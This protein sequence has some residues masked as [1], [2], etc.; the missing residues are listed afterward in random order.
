MSE[1]QA[2]GGRFVWYELMT[3]D[4]AAAAA[5]YGTVVGWTAKDAGM[6]GQAYT[7]CSAGPDTVAGLMPIPEHAKGMHPH[8]IG[9]IGVDDVDAYTE[10]VKAAG[11]M[12]HKDPQD[13]PGVGR[14]SVTGDPQGAS[15]CLFKA[16]AGYQG[17]PEAGPNTPGRIGWHELHSADG[18]QALEFYTGMFGWWKTGE[19]DMGS[20]G[21]YHLFSATETQ[22]GGI[23]TKMAG[24]PGPP[25]WL[26]YW[27]VDAIDAAAERV[28]AAG[29]K[30]MI[31]PHEVPGGTWI[32]QGQDPQGAMFALAAPKR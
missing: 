27:N 2:L 24:T 18:D 9:Y 4:M 16:A 15:F 19:V 14:F 25:M 20:S 21:K 11:G 31:G 26:L 30:V 12:V 1:S 5:F 6:P 23:M 8:W 29:G 7:L 13:I 10:K 32:V 22:M 17:S 28:R 3:T